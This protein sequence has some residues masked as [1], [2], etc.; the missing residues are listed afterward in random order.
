MTK[1]FSILLCCGFLSISIHA[2]NFGGGLILGLSTS[3]VSGDNLGGFN[4]AGVLVGAFV[5]K[6][7]SPL[8]S[9]QME[10]TYIQKGSKNPSMNKPEHPNYL[11]ED[12]SSSYIEVPLLLQY[13]QSEILKIEGGL[14]GAYLIEGYY[15][16]LSGR[17][18]IVSVEP[19]IKYDIGLLIGVDY[20]FSEKLSLNTRISNSILPIGA[21]DYNNTSTYN[22]N[23]KG[24]YNAI[25]S[26]AIHY[27]F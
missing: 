8:L 14:Q 15:N 4:G 7:I 6:S 3:Q 16:N 27:N 21:E 23:R 18:P 19:F 10:M 22:T 20:K 5:N 13:L 24:K 2:Q 25:L 1:K 11:L 9:F 17:M 26:F 12:I